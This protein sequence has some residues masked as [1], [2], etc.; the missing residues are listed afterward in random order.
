M[1]EFIILIEV[2]ILLWEYCSI[3][4]MDIIQG[5]SHIQ[6]HKWP[7]SFVGSND[8]TYSWKMIYVFK[9]LELNL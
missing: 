1:R 8:I 6:Q 4:P 5:L 7:V 2:N 3:D 9:F